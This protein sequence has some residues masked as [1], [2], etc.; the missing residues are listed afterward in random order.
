MYALEFHREIVLFIGFLTFT[1]FY[2]Y[3]K[4]R[5]KSIKKLINFIIFYVDL[6]ITSKINLIVKYR[7][8]Y[9]HLKKNINKYNENIFIILFIYD[10]LFYIY[11]YIYISNKLSNIASSYAI[12]AVL[13]T[14]LIPNIYRTEFI[15]TAFSFTRST[16]SLQKG[17]PLTLAR[18]TNSNIMYTGFFGWTKFTITTYSIAHFTFSSTLLLLLLLLLRL[19]LVMF[20]F[21]FFFMMLDYLLCHFL[22]FL[23]YRFYLLFFSFH[24]YVD[25]RQYFI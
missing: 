7:F 10:L 22:Y 20:Y 17:F 19:W 18:G 11:I 25:R 2:Y 6:Q 16:L 24:W 9:F 5:Q 1:L 13:N 4:N 14:A 8:I 15:E 21:L 12:L 3:K 23:N